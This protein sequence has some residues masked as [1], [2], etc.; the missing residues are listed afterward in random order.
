MTEKRRKRKQEIIEAA[1]RVWGENSFRNTSLSSISKELGISKTALY[2]YYS[3]KAELIEAMEAHFIELYQE[4]SEKVISAREE[5][6]LEGALESFLEIFVRFFAE[7]FHYLR[8]AQIHFLKKPDVG[9]MFLSVVFSRNQELFPDKVLSDHFGGRLPQIPVVT[10]FIFAVTSF[11]LVANGCEEAPGANIAQKPQEEIDVDSILTRC[12]ELIIHG[13]TGKKAS[14]DL[15]EK[16]ERERRVPD[17][18]A[19]EAGCRV[20]K[21]DYPETDRIIKAVSEVVARD[22]LWNATVES[23]ARNLGMSKSSLYF[24]FENRDQMLWEMIN[25]ERHSLGKLLLQQSGKLESFEEKLYAYFV[26]FLRYVWG[27]PEFLAMMNWFRFQEFE[28]HPPEDPTAGMEQYYHFIL[29][30][31]MRGII[32]SRHYPKEMVLRFMH[33]LLMQEITSCYRHGDDIGQLYPVLR[34]LHQLFLYGIEGA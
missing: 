23:I 12:R 28:I 18:A 16:G 30:A 31:G 6:S 19:I 33:F 8:F 26:L 22:G 2:R 29:E 32:D 11:L 24:Y 10:R 5:E 4:L 13:F 3:G 14:A 1:F 21:S 9:D 15:T 27:R 34:A 25:R 17:F 20:K 7:N